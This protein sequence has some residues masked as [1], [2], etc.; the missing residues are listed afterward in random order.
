MFKCDMK[1]DIKQY[2]NSFDFLSINLNLCQ[3]E[4]KV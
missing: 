4:K 1:V 2:K 3:C